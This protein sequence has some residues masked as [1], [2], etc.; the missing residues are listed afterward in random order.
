MGSDVTHCGEVGSGQIMKILNNMVLFQNVCALTEA[1]AVARRNA[2]DLDTLLSVISKGSGD[3]F[4]VRNHGRK[5][6]LP[7]IF[8]SRAFSTRYA[9]KDLGYALDL[10]N[11]V[12]LD[13]K[14]AKVVMERLTESEMAGFGDQYFPVLLNVIDPMVD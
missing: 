6:M 8:P 10:A 11:S 2:V 9:K 4:A 3:S 1:I 13:L 7:R 12:G 5:S 14:C